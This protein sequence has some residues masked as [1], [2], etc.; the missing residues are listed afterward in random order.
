MYIRLSL[1]DLSS[2]TTR[3]CAMPLS[4]KSRDRSN[5]SG[6]DSAGERLDEIAAGK[7]EGD[8]GR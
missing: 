5:S 1:M 4:D 6:F 8:H 2:L 3:F 7:A